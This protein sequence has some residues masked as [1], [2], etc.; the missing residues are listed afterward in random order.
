VPDVDA[1]RAH[2]LGVEGAKV[3]S[4]VEV[5]DWGERS[6]YLSDPFGNPLCFVEQG[7]EFTSGFVP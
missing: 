2:A 7:T 1:M 3:T 5:Q 4:E 6:F